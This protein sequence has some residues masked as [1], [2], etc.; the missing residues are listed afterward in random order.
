MTMPASFSEPLGQRLP[1]AD[2]SDCANQLRKIM[3]AQTKSDG[4]V[5]LDLVADNEKI[6][7]VLNSQ[8]SKLLMDLLRV[9]GRGDA[10][11]LVPVS[12]QL[13][14]Q[15]AADLLN[16]SRPYFISKLLDTKTIPYSK[17]GRHRRI[18]AADVFEYRNNMHRKRSAALEEL[19]EQDADL[20]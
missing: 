17:V 2:E 13:T 10:A 15:Q 7:V 5:V 8:L 4:E 1:N 3:A 16:V 11:T 20:L 6:Q 12:Q 14:T 18:S 19:A 9:I